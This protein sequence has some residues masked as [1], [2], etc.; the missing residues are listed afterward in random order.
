MSRAGRKRGH[1]GAGRVTTVS[2]ALRAA[3]FATIL[4]AL[5]SI[6][7]ACSNEPVLPAKCKDKEG[8]VL[9]TRP[10]DAMRI[11]YAF[12]EAKAAGAPTR[13]DEAGFMSNFYA[14]LDADSCGWF[15]RDKKNIWATFFKIDAR[16]G[17][18]LLFEGYEYMPN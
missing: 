1:R 2:G 4:L 12:W 15:V 17:K 7:P 3:S 6:Q 9:V 16:D 13:Y 11:A 5:Q 10:E 18:L 14:Y 8:N